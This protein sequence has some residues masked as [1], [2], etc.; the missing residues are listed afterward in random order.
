VWGKA[1]RCVLPVKDTSKPP[2]KRSVIH[3]G[4]EGDPLVPYAV[5]IACSLLSNI[6]TYRTHTFLS[7]LHPQG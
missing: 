7:L 4:W 3:F 1:R 6:A 5:G 2:T